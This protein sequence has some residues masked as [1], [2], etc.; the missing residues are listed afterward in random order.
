MS[1]APCALRTARKVVGA[2]EKGASFVIPQSTPRITKV[3]PCTINLL[4]ICYSALTK[5]A[6][7]QLK[8]QVIQGVNYGLSITA[9][10]L[11]ASSLPW[12]RYVLRLGI[13]GVGCVGVWA[14]GRDA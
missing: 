5:S 8:Q 2:D 9:S 3:R 4:P 12:I 11:Q 1:R 13:G 6:T 10:E 14:P 7:L